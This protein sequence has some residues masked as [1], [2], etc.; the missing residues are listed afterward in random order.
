M[1]SVRQAQCAALRGALGFFHSLTHSLSTSG[2]VME[3]KYEGD[4]GD[5]DLK[6]QSL[7]GEDKYTNK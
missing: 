3:L 4:T 1:H 5:T 6:I 7:L 2:Q